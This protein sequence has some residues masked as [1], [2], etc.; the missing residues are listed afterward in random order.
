LSRTRTGVRLARARN[1]GPQ[2]ERRKR[3]QHTLVDEKRE[4]QEKRRKKKP[5]GKIWTAKN[6]KRGHESVLET[7]G[8][9]SRKKNNETRNRR[10]RKT[11]EGQF[12]KGWPAQ[13]RKHLV[14]GKKGRKSSK[15]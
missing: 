12:E 7:G 8:V 1:G 6:Q 9:V 2:K 13:G 11:G 5:G 4:S 15:T 10:P 14:V 3:Q